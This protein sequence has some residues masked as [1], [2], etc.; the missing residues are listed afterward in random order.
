MFCNAPTK[1]F[2]ERKG[3]SIFD[4]HTIT[5]DVLQCGACEIIEKLNTETSP[6]FSLC[7]NGKMPLAKLT[8]MCP[9]G[10]CIFLHLVGKLGLRQA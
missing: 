8:R 10:Y 3:M 6:L 5:G 2:V 4:N 7:N 9:V 1:Y